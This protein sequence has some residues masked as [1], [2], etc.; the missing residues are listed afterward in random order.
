MAEKEKIEFMDGKMIK[1]KHL[2]PYT[3]L[4]TKDFIVASTGNILD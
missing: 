2:I 1:I 4:T 3:K